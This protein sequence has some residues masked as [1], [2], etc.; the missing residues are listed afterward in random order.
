MQV[1]L[2]SQRILPPS[3]QQPSDILL[4]AN[5]SSCNIESLLLE[6]M[7]LHK[8]GHICYVPNP[9]LQLEVIQSLQPSILLV[10]ELNC[11]FIANTIIEGM[12]LSKPSLQQQLW[13]TYIQNVIMLQYYNR[14]ERYCS[15]EEFIAN[16]ETK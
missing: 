6:L 3:L 5:R 2:W 13:K 9:L 15:Y 8:G 4:L 10:D 11:A 12:C 1:D 16:K 14:I 7:I